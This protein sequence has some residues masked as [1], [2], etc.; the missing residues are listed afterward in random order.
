MVTI[1]YRLGAFGW[2]SHPALR[3]ETTSADDRSGN[4]LSGNYLSG[5]YGTLDAVRALEWVRDNITVFGGDP[6]RVTVFGESAGGSD[7]Y[8]M[9][10]SPRAAGLFSRAIVQSGGLRW[11]APSHA[12]AYVDDPE[13]GHAFSSRE[14]VSK[15]LIAAGRASDREAA[16]KIAASMTA[17]E[18]A[19]FLRGR[20]AAEILS[21]Y[22]GSGMGGMYQLPKL[23]RDGRV[24][25]RETGLEAV[26][27]G[28]Y[29]RVPVMLG[30]NRDENKL[31]MLF[32]SDHVTKAM[33]LPLWLNDADRYY[34]G[35]RILFT[36]CGR[37][38]AWTSRRAP[39]VASR[40]RASTPIAS[41][42]TPSRICSGW[43]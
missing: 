9:I 26:A 3:G 1:H 11:T 35:H 15:Q 38:A 23:F 16:K 31:F 22:E 43:S 29:N 30:T 13:A 10:F 8:A 5:N 17:P 24:L 40:G 19:D 25:P 27:L 14:V 12:E 32:G 4:Y 41:I 37:R 7:T 6:D 20:S 21:A 34:A 2:F 36:S 42:G 28:H 39:C 18:L 33:G